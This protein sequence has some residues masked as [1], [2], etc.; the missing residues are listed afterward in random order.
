MFRLADSRGSIVWQE[1][2]KLDLQKLMPTKNPITPTNTPVEFPDR[3]TLPN[4]LTPGT[5]TLSI[6]VVDAG[7]YYEPLHLAIEGRARD[8]SYMLG[9]VS[10]T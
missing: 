9:K 4:T 3:F 5:Y 1:K 10:I 6:Q 7:H 8:G 2:S